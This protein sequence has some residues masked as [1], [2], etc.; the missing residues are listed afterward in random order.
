MDKLIASAQST[1]NWLAQGVR[2]GGSSI[3]QSL[4]VNLGAFS[5]TAAD[6]AV[7]NA[8][9]PNTSS[10]NAALNTNTVTTQ[11]QQPPPDTTRTTA[12]RQLNNTNWLGITVLIAFVA[13][14]LWVIW[15]AIKE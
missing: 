1:I 2:T 7:I 10:T 13:G 14:I 12:P 5:G 3:L 9:I 11:A 8:A 6:I 4:G 15:Q